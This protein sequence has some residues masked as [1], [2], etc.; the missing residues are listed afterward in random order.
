MFLSEMLPSAKSPVM[1]AAIE[2]ELTSNRRTR[3]SA[4]PQAAR[5]D[6]ALKHG[7]MAS[8]VCVAAPFMRG[9]LRC[10]C[11]DWFERTGFSSEAT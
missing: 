3:A 11:C 7:C 10:F 5:D 9:R 2:D 1:S 6:D 4:E 8:R